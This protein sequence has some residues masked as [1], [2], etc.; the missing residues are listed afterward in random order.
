MT[1]TR[2]PSIVA[3]DL[4]P[5]QWVEAERLAAENSEKTAHT[6]ATLRVAKGSSGLVVSTLSPIAA[7]SGIE[8]LRRGGNA[9]DAA[10]AAALVQITTALGTNISFAGILEAAY[11]DA[12]TRSTCALDA[13]WNAWSGELDRAS[14]PLSPLTASRFPGLGAPA[15]HEGDRMGRRTL[16]P[17]FMAGIG[18]LQ[19]RFG[20]LN[21]A[22]LLAPAIFY[23]EQGVTIS[24]AHVRYLGTYSSY[25]VATPSGRRFLSQSG[26]DVPRLGDRFVQSDLAATLRTVAQHGVRE[27]YTGA[28]AHSFVTAIAE[29]GGQASLDDA[30]RYEVQ[31]S[32]PATVRFH[33][34][35]I[36][37]SSAPILESLALIEHTGLLALP[38]YVRNADS[39]LALSRIV[40]WALT[41]ANS[42]A[43]LE[44]FRTAGV[45]L[46]LAG[47]LTPAY[48]RAVSPALRTLFVAPPDASSPP[49]ASRHSASVVAVD[50]QGN[51]CS[52][53]HTSNT[54]AWGST[55]LV[56]GGISIPDAAGYSAIRF[57]AMK[58]GDRLPHD[59]APLIAFKEGLPALA[60][61]AVGSSCIHESVQVM[62]ETLLNGS[63]VATALSAPPLLLATSEAQPGGRRLPMLQVP[64]GAYSSDL[65]RQLGTHGIVVKECSPREIVMLRGTPAVALINGNTAESADVPGIINFTMAC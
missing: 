14:I 16:V 2:S 18:A 46:S 59:M 27:M 1:D 22:D 64:A 61:S 5:Q 62:L 54:L 19:G 44:N 34:Y 58:P 13:G 11:H 51:I 32:E 65:I 63:D 42:P 9:A 24:P 45:D 30:A 23:A 57:P 35:D 39:L 41:A 56:V 28:W 50:A 21:L 3:K 43:W 8:T 6:P 33:G 31:W 49:S 52:L 25:L 26:R 12:K 60:L 15:A 48:A 53:L 38:P 47:R 29:A 20:V 36:R 55:G 10:I 7:L 40:T 37:T 4:S 17:G